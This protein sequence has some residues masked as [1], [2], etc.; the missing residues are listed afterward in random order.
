MESAKPR[1]GHS[2]SRTGRLGVWM[3][4]V[5]LLRDRARSGF[6]PEVVHDLRVALRRCRSVADTVE[7]ID[8]D[9]DWRV[10]KRTAKPLFRDL[11]QLRD[12]QVMEEWVLRIGPPEDPVRVALLAEILSRKDRLELVAKASLDAFGDKRWKGLSRKLLR[13][14]A[15]F[16]GHESVFETLALERLS[17][18]HSLHRQALARPS[19]G[20][21]HRL[22]IGIKRFRY[23]VENFL[24]SQHP[25]WITDLKHLQDLLGE[26]HDLDVLSSELGRLRPAPGD[27]ARWRARI[28]AER[29][30]RLAAYRKRASGHH[31]LWKEWRAG[32]PEGSRLEKATL[33]RL[34]I[35]GSFLDPE[36]VRA[37]SLRRLARDL[38]TGLNAL[39]ILQSLRDPSAPRFLE[40]AALLHAI[41]KSKRD[42]GYHKTSAALIEKL[43]PPPGWTAQEIREV[44]L[45][46]RYHRGATPRPRHAG[47]QELP[48]PARQ[49]VAELAAVLRLADALAG[50]TESRGVRIRVG[51]SGERVQIGATGHVET[52][53]SVA[54]THV[55]EQLTGRRF[56][57]HGAPQ[58][59]G[60][61]R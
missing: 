43:S 26:V 5:P 38:A 49:K 45:V 50:D 46:V 55:L 32:L 61:S 20:A 30:D 59:R 3:R 10:L 6:D 36:P 40:A 9:E 58:H 22:R 7:S 37:R 8:P 41:G 47:F 14:L 2:A 18:A 39:G 13:R 21:W 33:E 1:G 17:E 28:D 16:E 23:V 51:S 57:V 54:A 52:S 60:R 44:A 29:E 42:R 53:K 24:A 34:A 48:K 56:E 11:G 15:S 4:R 27:R 12:A 31:S 19:R 35:W 25:G